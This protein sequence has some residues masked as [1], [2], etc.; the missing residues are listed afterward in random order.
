MFKIA[1]ALILILSSTQ[2]FSTENDL[3]DIPQQEMTQAEK[4]HKIRTQEFFG[5]DWKEPGIYK[6]PESNSTLSLPKG[7]HLLIGDDANRARNIFSENQ[8]TTDLEALVYDDSC[9]HFIMFKNIDDG[10]VS[11]D[12]WKDVDAKELLE[13]IQEST[14]EANIERRKK[15][16]DDVNV[17]GWVQEP[18]LDK[19]TNTVYWSTEAECGTDEHSI[20]AV[21]LK[22]G[23][24]GFERF[25]W[26]TT[27]KLYESS[28][29]HLNAML[30]SFCF[31]PGFQYSDYTITDKIADYGIAS[32]VAAT[33][34]T[35]KLIQATG[36]LIIL[37]KFTG[38]IFIALAGVFYK[39]KEFFTQKN[40]KSPW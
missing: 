20:N 38:A 34:G 40:K 7:Y 8:R 24:K 28:T 37:K 6:L 35:G 2:L 25:T 19:Q 21:A 9:N 17:I 18:T 29:S 4:E 14:K 26:V 27:K 31:D 39:L 1:T 12:D 22:L 33:A 13:G 11:M 23:R 5:L 36:I 32:L 3:T 30:S 15:G 10:Y 16:L